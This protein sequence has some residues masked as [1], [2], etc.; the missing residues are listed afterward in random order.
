MRGPFVKHVNFTDEG[1]KKQNKTNK[2]KTLEKTNN[3]SSHRDSGVN[4]PD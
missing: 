1:I 4:E 3:G 2:Q